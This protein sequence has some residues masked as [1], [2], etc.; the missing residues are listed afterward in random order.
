MNKFKVKGIKSNLFV[1]VIKFFNKGIHS[2]FKTMV[3]NNFKFELPPGAD[4]VV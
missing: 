2:N 1:Y 3:S 4:H